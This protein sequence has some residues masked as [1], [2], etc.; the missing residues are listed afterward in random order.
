M[1]IL[2]GSNNPLVIQFDADIS[3]I[4][5][6]VISLWCDAPKYFQK[7]L[8]V[9]TRDDIS[10]TA[11]TAVCPLTE[12]ETASFPRADLVLE[13]KGLDDN[14]NTVFWSQYV[15][16]VENRRDKIISMTQTEG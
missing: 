4:P 9:W 14:D 15:I 6:I 1:A 12:E 2:Q 5:Q 13:A 11:D 8:K 7:P 10:I 3:E 16:G